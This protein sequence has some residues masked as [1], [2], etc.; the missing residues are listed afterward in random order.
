M[1][2][3]LLP[4]GGTVWTN[5][6]YDGAATE[7]PPG[8]WEM[9]KSATGKETLKWLR[10]FGTRLPLAIRMQR[11][12]EKRHLREPHFYRA[13]DRGAHRDAGPGCGIGTDAAAAP[14]SREP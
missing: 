10:A 12:M 1:E 11:A 6:G 8:A 4:N 14:E 3:Y 13:S 2:Q 7:L 9:P 5:A